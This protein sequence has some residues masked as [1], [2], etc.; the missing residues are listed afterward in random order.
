[1]HNLHNYAWKSLLF[2]IVN[3]QMTNDQRHLS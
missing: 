2:L 1:M 3:A